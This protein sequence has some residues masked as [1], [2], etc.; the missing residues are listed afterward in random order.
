MLHFR[1]QVAHVFCMCS[2]A[3]SGLH[4]SIFWSFECG[5]FEDLFNLGFP[6]GSDMG[7]IGRYTQAVQFNCGLIGLEELTGEWP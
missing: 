4:P 6:L 2:L 5:Q 3:S 7:I 1:Q